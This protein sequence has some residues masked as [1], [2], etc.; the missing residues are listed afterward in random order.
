MPRP[1]L[2]ADKLHN[3]RTIVSDYRQVGE[4]LWE[5]FNPESDQ[6]WYYSAL[7]G[8]F[9]SLGSPLAD[10]LLGALEE[11]KRLRLLP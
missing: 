9:T 5:R 8:A 4:E 3:L 7:A 11:L 1:P 10:E 2:E 6:A